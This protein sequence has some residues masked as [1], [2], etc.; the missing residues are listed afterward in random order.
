MKTTP[1]WW[2]AAEPQY[3][4]RVFDTVDCRILVVGSGYTGLS[5]AIT[6]AE[7]GETGITVVDAMRIG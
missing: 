3:G 4:E 1:F 5:A 6:L 2:E 7:A